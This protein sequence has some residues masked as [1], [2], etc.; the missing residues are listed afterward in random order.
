MLSFEIDT[1]RCLTIS[2]SP[3]TAHS[4]TNT[5]NVTRRKTTYKCLY[6]FIYDEF[7]PINKSLVIIREVKKKNYTAAL[8]ENM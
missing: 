8:P 4:N 5:T 3:W 7:A 2:T 6:P 1:T